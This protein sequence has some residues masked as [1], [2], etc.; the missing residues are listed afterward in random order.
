MLLPR[1]VIGDAATKLGSL[2]PSSLTFGSVHLQDPELLSVFYLDAVMRNRQS[3]HGVLEFP[4]VIDRYHGLC[5]YYSLGPCDADAL[6]GCVRSSPSL[7]FVDLDEASFYS[8][9]RFSGDQGRLLLYY[10][11][12]F[13]DRYFE[14]ESDSTASVHPGKILEVGRVNCYQTPNLCTHVDVSNG[15]SLWIL[16]PRDFCVEKPIYQEERDEGVRVMTFSAGVKE[17]LWKRYGADALMGACSSDLELGRNEVPYKLTFIH[18]GRKVAVLWNALVFLACLGLLAALCLVGW[19]L[20]KRCLAR[21]CRLGQVA[22]SSESMNKQERKE[23]LEQHVACFYFAAFTLGL[24]NMIL[25]AATMFVAGPVAVGTIVW[26]WC[27]EFKCATPQLTGFT[28]QS[29]VQ[30]V[31]EKQVALMS[32]APTSI[33]V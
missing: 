10:E 33:V 6:A 3:R 31:D 19:K 23:Q 20:L 21:C 28:Q 30:T 25:P 11:P 27:V 22:R 4:S 15:P 18:E 8:F 12:S 9:Q 7:L 17:C 24:I 29:E 1:F 16:F 2:L 14:A 26:L 32:D 5:R 13:L